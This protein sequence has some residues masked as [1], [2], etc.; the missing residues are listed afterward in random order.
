MKLY[1]HRQ[2]FIFLF[3]IISLMLLGSFFDY[4][5]S[6]KLYDAK[7]MFGIL[8]SAYGQ[9]PAMLCL[10]GGGG[11][12]MKDVFDRQTRK[13]TF[14]I[15]F[16]FVFILNLFVFVML[17]FDTLKYIPQMPLSIAVIISLFIIITVNIVIFRLCEN[18]DHDTL[19]KI[20]WFLILTPILTLLVVNIIKI[21]W[22]RPR[23]RFISTHPE[24]SFQPW[25][26]IGNSLKEPLSMQGI[27]ADEFKSFPSAHTACAACCFTTGVLLLLNKRFEGK[28][29]L[30]F[31]ISFIF[32]LMVGLSRIVA[33]AHFLSDI[34]CG[35]AISFFIQALLAKKIFHIK[36]V[37][38]KER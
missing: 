24:I 31:S 1:S 22:Q 8:L 2:L 28:G 26:M 36:S 7:H 3:V 23:M 10:I 5:I 33:G 6:L 13:E 21:F 4:Q 37:K 34:T 38:M 16:I 27:P 19:Q 12:L 30:L 9:L 25:W 17:S 29:Y 11:L 15:T 14:I 18:K 20:A 32:T 35:M